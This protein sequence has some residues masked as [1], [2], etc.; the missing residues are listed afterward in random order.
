MNHGRKSILLGVE[1]L[2]SR[3]HELLFGALGSGVLKRFFK[4]YFVCDQTIGSGH[5]SLIKISIGDTLEVGARE[6]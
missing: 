1:C 4:S 2:G 3:M 5:A 6:A